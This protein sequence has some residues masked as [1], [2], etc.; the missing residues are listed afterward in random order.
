MRTARDPEL[1]AH[2]RS[3][4]AR[5]RLRSDAGFTIIEVLVAVLVLTLGIVAL[6]GNFTGAQTLG[7]SAE[8][9]QTAVA[10]AEGQLER[11]RGLKWNE[12]ALKEEPARSEETSNPTH[13]EVTPT[14]TTCAGNGPSTETEHCYEWKW[15]APAASEP[16]VLLTSS[17]VTEGR[18]GIGADPRTVNVRAT[19]ATSS[20][21]RLTYQIYTFVT[22][23]YEGCAAAACKGAEDLKRVLVAVTGTHLNT[24][25]TLVSLVSDR[26]QA[27]NPVSPSTKCEKEGGGETACL[28]Q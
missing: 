5:A 13:H 3:S 15:E 10:L 14:S 7:T 1:P 20:G 19:T 24:P 6:F 25:V 12:L 2:D 27:G 23:A 21:T 18:E 17:Q 26:E 11:V 8:A 9:H 16:L 28:T 4:G 22:W